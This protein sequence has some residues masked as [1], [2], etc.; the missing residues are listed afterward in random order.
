MKYL[1]L[2]VVLLLVLAG[3]T[4]LPPAPPVCDNTTDDT[5][6]FQLGLVGAKL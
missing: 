2:I 4:N 1:S 3:S 5:Q 6:A